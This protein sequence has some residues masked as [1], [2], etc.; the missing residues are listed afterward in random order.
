[1]S[2]EEQEIFKYE[3]CSFPSALFE[4]PELM[5]LPNKASLADELWKMVSGLSMP[6]SLP[7]DIHYVVDGGCL[8]QRLQAP[9]RRGKTFQSIA[10]CYAHLVNT[11][12]P[13]ATIV[14]DGYQAG[15]TTKDMTHVRRSK[16]VKAVPVHFSPEMALCSTKEVFLS[17]KKKTSKGFFLSL[18]HVWSK[19]AHFSTLKQ[20]LTCRLSWQLNSQLKAKQR[21]SLGKTQIC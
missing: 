1:M 19:H 17:K 15:P 18:V 6:C 12:C 10:E 8:L 14:F 21:L 7:A 13:G 3:L 4:S 20:M 9:W 2:G 11:R 16:G 5:R